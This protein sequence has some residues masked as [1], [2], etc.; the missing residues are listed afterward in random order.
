MEDNIE[1]TE[2]YKRLKDDFVRTRLETVDECRARNEA[3]RVKY[4]KANAIAAAIRISHSSS[5]QFNI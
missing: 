3:L 1:L 5:E 4:E 2:Q